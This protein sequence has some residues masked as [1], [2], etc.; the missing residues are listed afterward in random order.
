VTC[1]SYGAAAFED[2]EAEVTIHSSRLENIDKS[3]VLVF[4]KVSVCLSCGKADF[5][6]PPPQLARLSTNSEGVSNT[7]KKLE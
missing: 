7:V 1:S 4:V 6:M 3:P 2:F 5:V